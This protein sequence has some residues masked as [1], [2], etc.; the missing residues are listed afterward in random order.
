L[1]RGAANDAMRVCLIAARGLN[2][3]FDNPVMLFRFLPGNSR[4]SVARS[5]A[6]TNGSLTQIQFLVSDFQHCEYMGYYPHLHDVGV[7]SVFCAQ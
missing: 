7:M 2:N 3:A 1:I 6:F 5:W 4:S